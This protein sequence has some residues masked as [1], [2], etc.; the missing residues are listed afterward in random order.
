MKHLCLQKNYFCPQ[1]DVQ[2]DKLTLGKNVVND[3]AMQG[4]VYKLVPG[5]YELEM[6][7]RKTFYEQNK[8]AVNA[9]LTAEE[10][11]ESKDKVFLTPN[12]NVSFSLEYWHPKSM[13][14]IKGYDIMKQPPDH[15]GQSHFQCS[16]ACTVLHLQKLIR[17]KYNL[18]E[19][20]RIDILHYEECLQDDLTLMD[21][22]Y[23]YSWKMDKPLQ[24]FYR[25]LESVTFNSKAE[26]K[27]HLISLDW[28]GC[29]K[30]E[31]IKERAKKKPKTR[32]AMV[33]SGLVQ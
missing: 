9:T 15:Q 5:L 17:L 23:I 18:E 29:D 4:I 13:V 33:K 14:I 8:E 7:R 10:L 19:K 3:K 11:G 2:V 20:Y 26:Y 31:V 25:I 1:C 16:S 27:K 21:V 24:F 32:V 30:E 28:V 12:D 22:A 6:N